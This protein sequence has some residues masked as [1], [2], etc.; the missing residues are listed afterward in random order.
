LRPKSEGL[1]LSTIAL[2]P[3]ITPIVNNPILNTNVEEKQIPVVAFLYVL[4]D[5]DT[6]ND[7]RINDSDRKQIAISNAAGTSFKVLVDE[8]DRFNGYSAIKNNRLSVFYTSSDKLKVAEI[9]LRSQE[10][11][12]NSEFSNQP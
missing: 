3:N 5:K 11:V 1:F 7:N 4:V 6:N 2:A 12:S 9:D 8:V 10:I